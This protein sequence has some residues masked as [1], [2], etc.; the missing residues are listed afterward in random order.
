MPMYGDGDFWKWFYNKK[1][2]AKDT[3]CF[4]ESYFG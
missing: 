2:Y 3:I 4:S 1:H